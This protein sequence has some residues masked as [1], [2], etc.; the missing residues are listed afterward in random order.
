MNLPKYL[1]KL[2]FKTT[3]YTHGFQGK[4]KKAIAFY[5]LWAFC[6]DFT[7][8]LDPAYPRELRNM[9]YSVVKQKDIVLDIGCGT[10]ISTIYA[11]EI[12]NKVIGIDM[13][14]NMLN[15][16]KKKISRKKIINIEVLYGSFPEALSDKLRFDSIISSFALAHFKK[17]QLILQRNVGSRS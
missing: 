12:A 14:L 6:Y 1:R 2:Y 8:K 5:K 9:I 11:S 16:L 7:I 3:D 17:T 4:Q 15:R 10:G 13:S